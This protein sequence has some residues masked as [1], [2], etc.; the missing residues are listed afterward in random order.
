MPVKTALSSQVEGLKAELSKEIELNAGLKTQGAQQKQVHTAQGVAHPEHILIGYKEG[1]P[2][3]PLLAH[4]ILVGI[5]LP[6]PEIG[7]AHDRV[8]QATVAYYTPILHSSATWLVCAGPD[9][10]SCILL[11]HHCAEPS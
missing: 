11:V 10:G 3:D 1:T 6:R 7:H 9:A 5:W 2:L 4:A 8:S